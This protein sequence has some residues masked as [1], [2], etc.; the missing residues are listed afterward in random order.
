MNIHDHNIVVWDL[1]IR[2]PI[3][4]GIGWRDYDKMGISVGCS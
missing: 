1:E 3:A 2:E 4:N